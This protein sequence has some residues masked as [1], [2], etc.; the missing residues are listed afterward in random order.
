MLNYLKLMTLG[1][2]F[3]VAALGADWARDIAY[4]FHALL[5]MFVSAG[6]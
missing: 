3:F 5:I 4:Q 1:L 2:I 6:M